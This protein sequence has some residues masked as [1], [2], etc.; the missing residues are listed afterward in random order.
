MNLR[1]SGV[2][3]CCSPVQTQPN[4]HDLGSLPVNLDAVSKWS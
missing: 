2:R 4:K 1:F 3:L